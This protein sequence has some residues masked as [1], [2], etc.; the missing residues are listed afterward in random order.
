MCGKGGQKTSSS[1]TYTPDP[2]AK[3]AYSDLI[4]QAQG[5]AQTPYNP[6]TQQQV[7]GLDPMQTSAFQGI[8]NMQGSYQP[9][10]NSATNYANSAA[11]PVSSAD[12]S[13]YMN[14]YQQ[15]VIDATMAQMAQNNAIQQQQVQGNATAAGAL[16]GDRM[17]VAQALTAGQQAMANNQTLANLNTSN[18]QNAQQMALQDKARQGQAAYTMGSLGSEQQ[19]LGLSGYSAL[20]GAGAAQQGQQQNVLNANTQNAQQQTMWPYQNTQWLASILGGLGPLMGGTSEGEQKTSQ[21]SGAGSWI[22]PAISMAAMMFSDRRVKEDVHEIGKT[23][24][25]QP[26]YK[27][28]YKGDPRTQIGLMAQ[29]VEKK[30]PES[31]GSLGGIKTVDYDTATK[32]AE[33]YAGGGNVRGGGQFAQQE[34]GNPFGFGDYMGWAPIKTAQPIVPQLP[35]APQKSSSSGGLPGLSQLQSLMGGG[36]DGGTGGGG[37]VSSDPGASSGM[38][39]LFGSLF[40]GFADGGFTGLPDNTGP[41][42]DFS[43]AFAPY[44]R[45]MTAIE[46]VM[47][48]WGA[49]YGSKV[50]VPETGGSNIEAPG[51]SVTTK[52]TPADLGGLQASRTAQMDPFAASKSPS[53]MGFD[54]LQIH[55]GGDPYGPPAPAPAVSPDSWAPIPVK[56]EMYPTAAAD[57]GRSGDLPPA[58]TP[59]GQNLGDVLSGYVRTAG[60]EPPFPSSSPTA[61]AS[62]HFSSISGS[63]ETGQTDPLKGVSNISPDTNN[64]KSYG[65]YGLNSQ[66]GASAWQFRDQYGSELGLTANPGTSEFDRQWKNAAAQDPEKL[67]A[68]END[69]WHKNISEPVMTHMEKAGVPEVIA[70]DPRVQA[71]M[72]DREVQQGPG[73]TQNH[74][75]RIQQAVDAADGDPEKFIHNMSDLDKKNIKN[76]FRTYLSQNPDNSAGLE[77][78]VTNREALALGQSPDTDLAGRKPENKYVSRGTREGGDSGTKTA[79]LGAIGTNPGERKGPLSDIWNK[80][81]VLGLSDEA[82]KNIMMMGF[83]SAAAGYGP[84]AAVGKGGL[85]TMRYAAQQEQQHFSQAMQTQ[86]AERQ[87][88]QL[89]EQAKH[90]L[91]QLQQQTKHFE[92]TEQHY[93]AQEE[94]WKNKQGINTEIYH[95]LINQGFSPEEAASRVRASDQQQKLLTQRMGQARQ[96]AAQDPRY[97]VASPE[98]KDNMIRQSYKRLWGAEPPVQGQPAAKPAAAPAAHQTSKPQGTPLKTAVNKDGVRIGLFPG[99]KQW[100]NLETGQPYP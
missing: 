58:A 100:V 99:S 81:N 92:A 22:G 29:D 25:G 93:K 56:T 96:D 67:V 4:S 24:D 54:G 55:P 91:A 3:A 70:A 35:Q 78:R 68:M 59:T 10:L 63:L 39:D 33:K 1:N 14:P 88:K 37:M 64:S 41:D 66:S 11:G 34:T 32:D 62:R 86:S 73:S 16:G 26:I 44:E 17:A 90:H 30:H 85:E 23:N 40:A 9:Y 38:G 18:Y 7:A 48:P 52:E 6:A 94:M 84:W 13:G 75:S 61:A 8:Q 77:N 97:S 15:K 31:V 36:G 60:G 76:D 53:G 82:R 19:N 45:D 72:A 20:A 83:A 79:G 2:Q 42:A 12:I 89:A 51:V 50:P 49:I 95:D 57:L 74:T 28:K 69:W 5:V 47:D 71:Y 65:N 43:A 98:Q 46:R 21:S 27:F 87:A 80:M